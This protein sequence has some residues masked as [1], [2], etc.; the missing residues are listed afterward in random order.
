MQRTQTLDMWKLVIEDEE[1]K[2]TVVHLTREEYSVGRKEGHAIRLT[3]RNVSRSHAVLRKKNGMADGRHC[4]TLN[5]TES[6][7]GVFVNGVRLA[8]TQE[9]LHGDL[10]QIGD[11]RIVIQDDSVA[12]AAAP[13]VAPTADAEDLKSTV[14]PGK[15]RVTGAQLLQRPNRLV[16]LIGPTPG[17][18]Y[19]LDKDRIIIGRAEEAHV[20]VNHNSVSRLHCEVH[21]L[22]ENRFEIVD[23]GSSNG[24]RVNGADLSRGIIEAG[25]VIELGD[26]RFKFIGAGQVFVANSTESQQLA[27]ISDREAGA[28][29]GAPSRKP[30][31]AVWPF[32]LVG[33]LL[34]GIAVG[35]VYFITHQQKQETVD[36][37]VV[38]KPSA[39]DPNAG[40]PGSDHLARAQ[41]MMREGKL[42]EAH[43]ALT[44]VPSDSTLRTT[45]DFKNIEG[46]WAS[47][48]LDKAEKETSSAAKL[49]LLRAVLDNTSIDDETKARAQADWDAAQAAPN[50][51][52]PAGSPTHTGPTRNH[53][54]PDVPDVPNT[55]GPK[56]NSP[57]APN[58]FPSATATAKG[59]ASTEQLL[60]QA[61]DAFAARNYSR[62]EDLARKAARMGATEGS[63][64]AATCCAAGKCPG[65]DKECRK[66][67]GF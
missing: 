1:G 63:R 26:V 34:G 55:P 30:S 57:L 24:V 13:A 12:E 65:N 10:V 20:S 60:G 42:D 15:V 8:E 48:Q 32:V 27:A 49:P 21:T 59:P 28:M 19:P 16:M 2:R 58:P 46:A 35:V 38:V 25:D 17:A 23:K 41:R 52:S 14:V 44:N 37:G 53:N 5:D 43:Q 62:C 54:L 39:T 3:E 22:A 11:Y 4:Y 67:C 61:S 40:L 66:Q 31:T 18:E 29:L 33:L 7:N 36:P 9:I 50:G 6:Y 45:K 51:T 64:L 56:P 47:L